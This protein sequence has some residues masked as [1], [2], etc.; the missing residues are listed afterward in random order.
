[1]S[2]YIPDIQIA[3]E[4]VAMRRWLKGA[5]A[6]YVDGRLVPSAFDKVSKK[7]VAAS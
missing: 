4:P 2:E 1:M 3:A 5:E 7:W 6:V